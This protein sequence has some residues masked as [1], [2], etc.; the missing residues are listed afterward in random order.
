MKVIFYGVNLLLF[1]IIVLLLS[2]IKSLKNKDVSQAVPIIESAEPV[3]EKMQRMK[4]SNLS[5][6]GIVQ[7]SVFHQSR[8]GVVITNV[9]NEDLEK[10][11]KDNKTYILT[12]LIQAGEA[13]AFITVEEEKKQ[14][15]RA[16][17]PRLPQKTHST[18]QS[19]AYKLG[20]TIQDS[21]YKLKEINT[22]KAYVILQTGSHEMKLS[23][24]D[25]KAKEL[26]KTK[27][28]AL[29]VQKKRTQKLPTPKK[30]LNKQ[31]PNNRKP[32]KVKTPAKV[33]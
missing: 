24:F 19:V 27:R 6:D 23:I 28:E 8:Q 7:R 1:V 29:N 5:S 26:A 32:P 3:V 17:V 22:V 2:N 20:D 12:G 4:I 9:S 11:I 33:I 25:D 31:T 30:P 16:R 10:K 14:S 13:V 15:K 18:S 21:A